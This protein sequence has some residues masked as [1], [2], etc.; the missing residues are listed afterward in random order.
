MDITDI[1]RIN[2]ERA[3]RWHG[4]DFK[5]W[6]TLE[7]AGAM[8]GEAGE[9][10]NYAKKIKRMEDRLAGNQFSEHLTENQSDELN[11]YRDKLGL[12]L[13]DTFLY[14]CLLASRQ[15]LN[16]EGFIIRKFNSK[17]EEMGFPERIG[18]W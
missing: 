1:Q 17:S 13:A 14:M 6:S 15:G 7:W 18:E 9:A 4:G 5:G 10:A 12:E 8:C 16:L 2:K 3:N 11:E